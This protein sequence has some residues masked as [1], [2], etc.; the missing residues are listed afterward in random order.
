MTE[1]PK[2]KF[3]GPWTEIKLDA[4][5]DYLNFYQNA[6]K[7]LDFETWYVD[8]FAGT[9]DRHAKVMK[10]GIFDDAPIEE[11]EQVLAG[12][13]LRALEVVPP[14]KRYWFS[15]ARPT[16]VKALEA[17]RSA[18]NA[19]IVVRGGDANTELRALFS[20]P[21]WTDHA[22]SRKQ[23]AVVFLDPYGMSV[24]FDTL[25]MLAETKRTDVWYLFPRK[26]VIQQLARNSGGLDDDK[27]ASLSRIFGC[28]DWEE[29]F[30][31][32]QPGQV[33]LFDEPETPES[34]RTANGEEIAKF[35]R[36][37]FGEIFG[38]VSDPIPL[39]ING[40]DFFELYCFSNNPRAFSLIKKGVDFVVK[41]YTPASR[42]R[43]GP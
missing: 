17:L 9:G 13:A 43:S 24:D 14:F 37:R 33:G 27:R 34:V 25:R 10:G 32:A 31:K 1:K 22:N 40:R 7:N 28:D 8:A 5:S 21:P 35:A 16:R 4:I 19:D 26:A 41:K 38:F 30:Y 15:E 18:R 42:R 20:S 36:Q 2:H 29:R 12:S 39:L 6:L 23:R 11:V 3:G